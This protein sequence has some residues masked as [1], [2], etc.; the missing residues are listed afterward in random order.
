MEITVEGP[1]LSQ[2]A[3]CGPIL[4]ALP[5]WF[6]IEEATQQ[7]I[8][9]IAEMPTFLAWMDGGC[10]GFLTLRLHT[11]EAAEIHVMGVHPDAQRRGVGRALLD[12]AEA[13]L[14]ASGAAYLQVKTLSSR[15]RS[16]HYARTR[17]YYTAMGFAAL[18]EW[19]DLWGAANP[20][21]QMVKKL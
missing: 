2:D 15:H 10:V 21:L 4:R 3:L 8:R 13:W 12:A 19:P 1:L 7:Y 18:E 11:P 6:G 17:A 16:E 20:C 14:R 9:D 5:D